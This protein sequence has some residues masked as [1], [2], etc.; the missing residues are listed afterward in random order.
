MSDNHAD[1]VAGRLDEFLN[2]PTKR[3]LL[4]KGKWGVGKTFY[5]TKT[6]LPPRLRK[7]GRINERLYAYVSL[8]GVETADDLEQL[9]LA[10][11][12][13]SGDRNAMHFIETGIRKAVSMAEMVPILKDYQG[14]VRRVGHMAIRNTLVCIDEVERKAAGLPL[15]SVMGLVSVLREHNGCRF[16][17]IMNDEQ[18]A[19]DDIECFKTY[20]EKVIDETVTYAPDVADNVRLIFGES[21]SST[22]YTEIFQRIGVSNIRVMQQAAWAVEHFSPH[23]STLETAVKRLFIEHIVLLTAFFHVPSLGVNIDRLPRESLLVYYFQKDEDKDPE[24]KRE[25]ETARQYGYDI[26]EY[27]HLIVDY[28]KQGHCDDAILRS[29]LDEANERERHGQFQVKFTEMWAP[30]NRSFK[31]DTSDVRA[32][33]ETFLNEYAQNM[34]FSQLGEILRL[35]DSLGLRSKRKKW[36]DAWIAPRIPTTGLKGLRDLA[37]HCTSRKLKDAITKREKDLKGKVPIAKL[38]TKVV[39]DSGWNPET[40][41]ELGSCDADDFRR[42]LLSHDEEHFLAV[43][44]NFCELWKQAGPDEKA[45][46]KKV[47]DALMSIAKS[48]KLNRMRV[49]MIIPWAFQAQI[50]ASEPTTNTFDA[51]E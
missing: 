21:E 20:R 46:E 18:I 2:H 23:T 34:S 35:T 17:L 29:M 12:V 6:Y 3:V 30:Y 42:E 32:S 50:T 36:I 10:S 8:F 43:V 37:Q 25:M 4:L 28:L 27:D 41:K 14:L 7:P 9:I 33:F 13:K 38:I 51:E 47:E 49:Q 24:H 16:V 15:A 1:F 22:L 26:Q 40:V 11:S 31:A 44:H 48:S 5:W 45:V 19:E 39:D